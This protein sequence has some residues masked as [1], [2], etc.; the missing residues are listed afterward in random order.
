M[1]KITFDNDNYHTVLNYNSKITR[2]WI[3]HYNN[4]HW[5]SEKQVSTRI[6]EYEKAEHIVCHQS[7]YHDVLDIN[8][9][10][11]YK[12]IEGLVFLEGFTPYGFP[13]IYNGYKFKASGECGVIILFNWIKVLGSNI[14]SHLL[15]TLVGTGNNLY[16]YSFE[17]YYSRIIKELNETKENIHKALSTL[18]ELNLI[19]VKRRGTDKLIIT[20]NKDEIYK[21]SPKDYDTNDSLD[22]INHYYDLSLSR[23]DEDEEVIA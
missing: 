13:T 4:Y 7:L 15:A 20:L 5:P 21:I 23:D 17:F 18:K 6:V 14:N 8:G 11:N 16:D 22:S 12:V 10:P 2:Y 3:D 19:T 9:R 1:S